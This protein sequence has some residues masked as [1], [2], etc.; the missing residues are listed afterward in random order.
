MGSRARVLSC[1]VPHAALRFHM[2]LPLARRHQSSSELPLTKGQSLDFPKSESPTEETE[3]TSREIWAVR[4]VAALVLLFGAHLSD[5]SINKADLLLVKQFRQLP[6]Y[7]PPS[8]TQTERNCTID[9]KG[10]PPDLVN[11]F[12][13]W[14]VAADAQMPEGLTRDDII[15]LV[16]E[17]GF[18]GDLVPCKD[19]V[20]RGEA[21]LAE[22]RRF[23][24]A[25]LQES[26]T[27]I[28][29]LAFP[30]DKKIEVPSLDDAVEILKKKVELV[31][32]TTRAAHATMMGMESFN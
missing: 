8:Q 12:A 23:L 24:C 9:S 28:S 7:W 27:L 15:V 29:R 26:V 11:V 30:E 18:A 13:E 3:E 17:F 14:F 25:G 16:E 31:N 32:T 21:H 4:A 19:F 5:Y 1:A 6:L 22:R 2:P 10:L 20:H